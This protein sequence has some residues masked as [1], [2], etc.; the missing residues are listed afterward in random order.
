MTYGTCGGMST[1]PN[2]GQA[3]SDTN[4]C[5]SGLTCVVNGTQNPCPTGMET[6]CSCFSNIF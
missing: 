3:C 4:P 1:C 5:C 6:G 2:A